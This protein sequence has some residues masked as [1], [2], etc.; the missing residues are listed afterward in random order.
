M[1]V[2][3]AYKAAVFASETSE[4]F[5]TF[6]KIDHDDLAEPIYLCNDR[7]DTVSGGITYIGFPFNYIAPAMSGDKAPVAKLEL[8]N[9]SRTIVEAIRGLKSPPIISTFF[10][11]V[12]DPESIEASWPD[13]YLSDAYYD[14][15]VV[16]GTLLL[17]SLRN[18]PFPAHS[19]MP[20]N[21]PGLFGG[22]V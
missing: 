3:A 22:V 9:V 20:S 2:S 12:S 15:L 5:I 10:A 8:D 17:E 7:V 1:T 11:M 13:F 4:A 6:L 19:F 14:R 21:F 16:S 18:E